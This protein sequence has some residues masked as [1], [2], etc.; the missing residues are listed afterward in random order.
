MTN[1][2]YNVTEKS[3]RTLTTSF[4]EAEETTFSARAALTKCRKQGITRSDSGHSVCFSG[5]RT[6]WQQRLW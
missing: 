2:E 3:R 1:D 4:S 5:R 6:L